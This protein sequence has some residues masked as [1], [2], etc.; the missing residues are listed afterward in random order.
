M[1]D[2]ESDRESDASESSRGKSPQDDKSPRSPSLDPFDRPGN[3]MEQSDAVK[4]VGTLS[5]GPME[6]G[7][8]VNWKEWLEKLFDQ[9]VPEEETRYTKV[10][11]HMLSDEH[12]DKV[13][14]MY[15]AEN[16]N[17]IARFFEQR[18]DLYDRIMYHL[19]VS[20]D[21]HLLETLLKA[22]QDKCKQYKDQCHDLKLQVS[23]R[24]EAINSLAAMFR[25]Q[26]HIRP[27]VLDALDVFDNRIREILKAF[28]VQE[29]SA[30]QIALI[31]KI[32]PGE[33]PPTTEQAA[34]TL[35]N[36]HTLLQK[37]KRADEPESGSS[38][39]RVVASRLGGRGG[40]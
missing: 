27:E 28:R 1:S 6:E 2:L 8:G 12:Y 16:D 23:E 18:Q 39:G 13:R 21:V 31:K 26:K 15:L 11:R 10:L 40:R 25:R 9:D 32:S 4:N 24:D 38:S 19:S 33:E 22:E 30:A 37:R 36:V 7:S 20:E 17:G 34:K 14:R 29:F 35:T 3:W 5:G